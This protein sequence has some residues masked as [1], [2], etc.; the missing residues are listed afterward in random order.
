MRQ[1]FALKVTLNAFLERHALGVEQFRFN[2]PVTAT[3][4]VTIQHLFCMA[5]SLYF[6][7]SASRHWD[8][9]TVPA[10]ANELRAPSY[11]GNLLT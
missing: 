2:V 3:L 4:P 5:A 10:V 8:A 9:L 7:H 1:Y 6:S 11:V